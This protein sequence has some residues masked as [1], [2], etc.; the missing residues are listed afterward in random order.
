MNES[1]L[2][3]LEEELDR[4]RQ[5]DADR[6]V[7]VVARDGDGRF[8]LVREYR[9]VSYAPSVTFPEGTAG[10]GEEFLAAAG[11]ALREKAGYE[12]ATFV[13]IGHDTPRVFFATGLR[14]VGDPG[15]GA[16]E[17]LF[18]DAN[19]IEEAILSG[20]IWDPRVISAWRLTQLHSPI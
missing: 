7:L 16:T 10:P 12:A 4:S 13:E 1:N 14:R 18:L 20:T 5:V 11:R 8:L 15:A 17:T 6:A 2:T 19:Q 9:Y 3:L